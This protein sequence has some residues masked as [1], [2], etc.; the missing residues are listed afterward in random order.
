MK[1]NGQNLHASVL[2]RLIDTDPGVAHEPVQYRLLNIGQIK[3]SVIRD[4]ENLLNTRRQILGPPAECKEVSKS[5]FVYGL[6]DFTA[7]NP[8]SPGVRQQLRQEIQKLIS[9]FEPRLRNVTVQLDKPTENEQNLHF[10][11][12]GLLVVD[13]VVEPVTFDTLFDPNKGQYS[14]SK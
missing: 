3:T 10:R 6:R 11:I 13:P 1:E 5:L 14:I 12:N 9:Q 4:L 2:D 8:K 7:E